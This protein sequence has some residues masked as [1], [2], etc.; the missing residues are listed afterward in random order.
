MRT[1]SDVSDV[2]R[3][4]TCSKLAAKLSAFG[5]AYAAPT[6]GGRIRTAIKYANQ[7]QH[8]T[9]LAVAYLYFSYVIIRAAKTGT[10]VMNTVWPFSEF[11]LAL[12]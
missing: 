5:E 3:Q 2:L 11:K 1:E 7:G 4:L 9:N 8:R 10:N 6:L 12:A